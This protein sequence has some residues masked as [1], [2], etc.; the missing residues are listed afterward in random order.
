MAQVTI[1]GPKN[2]R[3]RRP[4]HRDNK[5]CVHFT[6]TTAKTHSM[7]NDG[8]K[9]ITRPLPPQVS[10]HFP[11]KA[12]S[13]AASPSTSPAPDYLRAGA[14]V[15]APHLCCPPFCRT[16]RAG[17]VSLMLDYCLLLR[18]SLDLVM[19]NTCYAFLTSRLRFGPALALPRPRSTHCRSAVHITNPPAPELELRPKR[20]VN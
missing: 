1:L 10:A 9:A 3:H 18:S 19:F 14:A 20:A 11:K 2:F 6:C 5:P 4:R 7:R 16:I 8:R 15:D 17:I 12:R 13:C